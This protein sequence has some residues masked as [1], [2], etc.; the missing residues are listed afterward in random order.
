MV[1]HGPWWWSSGQRAPLLLR[2]S[3]FES[4]WLLILLLLYEKTKINEKEAGVG[5]FKKNYLICDK[6]RNRSF[7]FLVLFPIS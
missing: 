3:E 2:R 4:R 5:L 7:C 1:H 6:M